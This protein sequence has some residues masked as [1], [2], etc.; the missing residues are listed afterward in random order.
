MMLPKPVVLQ[1]PA[2][3]SPLGIG[4]G[5][6]NTDNVCDVE[7]CDVV[8]QGVSDEEK[9]QIVASVGIV[10]WLVALCLL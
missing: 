3:I 8:K 7:S 1:G 2:K 10:A 5:A 4:L 6:C 9:E